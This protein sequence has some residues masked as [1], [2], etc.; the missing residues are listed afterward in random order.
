MKLANHIRE[1][2][3]TP[4]YSRH[5][6]ESLRRHTYAKFCFSRGRLATPEQFLKSLGLDPDTALRG[7]DRWKP[8]LQEAVVDFRT[9]AR[10]GIGSDEGRRLL[11]SNGPWS[12]RSRYGDSGTV[13]YGVTRA[14]QPRHVI[15]ETGVAAGVS[16]AFLCAALIENGSGFL[17]SIDLPPAQEASASDRGKSS[18]ARNATIVG[19][20]VPAIIRDAM[21]SR[22]SLILEDVRTALP[23][24]LNQ[25]PAVDLF[26][27]DDLHR[28]D[29]MFWEY[30]L[31]WHRLQFRRGITVGRRGLRLAPFLRQILP[32]RSMSECSSSH[33]GSQI[34]KPY[35]PS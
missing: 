11:R 2:T 34:L 22:C 21:A 19:W 1:I 26:F 20:A 4:Y 24:L 28:P 27:H 8:V 30:Q 18:K 25:L 17:H 5:P 9:S 10:R 15:T 14:I 6:L 35:R 13:L 23:R 31:V 33:R 32:E 7:F 3:R 29:H 12:G 16:N